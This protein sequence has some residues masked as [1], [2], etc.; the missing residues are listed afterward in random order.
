LV[1]GL[2]EERDSSKDQLLRTL[3]EAKRALIPLPDEVYQT[4][5]ARY[6]PG[7]LAEMAHLARKDPDAAG[8]LE[9]VPWL[10][11]GRRDKRVVQADLEALYAFL[12]DSEQDVRAA[13]SFALSAL[14]Q[15][16]PEQVCAYILP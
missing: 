9:A 2:L 11:F 8:R 14:A 15:D 1:W 4:L 16:D 13:A 12:V 10:E 3:I 7:W 5:A 6:E